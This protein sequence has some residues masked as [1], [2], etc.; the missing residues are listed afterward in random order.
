MWIKISKNISDREFRENKNKLIQVDLGGETIRQGG[1]E[2]GVRG[3]CWRGERGQRQR[4]RGWDWEGGGVVLW[5]NNS[6]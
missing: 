3:G 5:Y 6:W 2:T 1:V 4:L